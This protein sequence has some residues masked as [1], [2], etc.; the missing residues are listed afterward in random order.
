MQTG[1]D[2]DHAW[3][4]VRPNLDPKCSRLMVFLRV[5]I[6]LLKNL[7]FK[8]IGQKPNMLR[9]EKL[10]LLSKSLVMAWNVLIFQCLFQ[11]RSQNECWKSNTH[12]RET[13]GSS[14][15]S[16]QL[17]PFSKWKLLSKERIRSQR[18]RIPLW[19]VPYS[20]EDHFYHIKWPPLNVTTFITYMRNLHNGRYANVLCGYSNDAKY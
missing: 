16:L 14:N 4:N 8:R 19:A 3:Q 17:C 9:I 5:F 1:L 15:D 18:E 6:F 11:W 20:M 13:T 10:S 7:T 12:Q 2:P